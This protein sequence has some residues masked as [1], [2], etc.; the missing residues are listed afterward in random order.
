MKTIHRLRVLS[1]PRYVRRAASSRVRMYQF[2]EDLAGEGMDIAFLPLLDQAYLDTIYSGGRVSQLGVAMAMARRFAA[3]RSSAADV[4]WIEKESFPFLPYA[5]ERIALGRI[6]YVVDYDDAVFHTYDH[7]ASPGKRWLLDGK[8][9]SLMRGAAVVTAG[10]TYIARYATASGAR[11]VRIIPSVVD[12]RAYDV[13]APAADG[14]A[15]IVGWIGT[16]KTQRLLEHIRPALEPLL[17]AGKIRLHL[18]GVRSCAWAQPGISC[19]PWEE[20]TEVDAIRRIDI[21]IMPVVDE[22]FERGKCGYKLIQYMACGKPVIASPVGCNSE[23]V[24]H[25]RIGFLAHDAAD[26]ERAVMDLAGNPEKRL[27]MGEAGRL[28][29]EERYS[30]KVA[31]PMIASALRCAAGSAGRDHAEPSAIV[32]E[33]A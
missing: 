7:L 18:I 3:M 16:P 13:G 22:A 32:G 31:A 21:G 15:P 29:A 19:V 11:D 14:G 5:I 8:I 23:I 33:E 2:Q 20:S 6:P 27:V 30:R 10:N 4:L 25:G 17:S 9:A 28:A 26:W 24:S 12:T 1:L